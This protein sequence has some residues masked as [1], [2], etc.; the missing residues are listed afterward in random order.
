LKKNTKVNIAE[1]DAIERFPI[2]AVKLEC[3]LHIEKNN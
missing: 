1:K 3:L 2:L